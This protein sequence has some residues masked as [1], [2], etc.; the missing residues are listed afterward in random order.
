MAF[1]INNFVIDE[2]KRV[3]SRNPDTGAMN[4]L[5]AQIEDAQITCDSEEVTKNDAKGTPIAKWSQAKTANFSASNSLL[6]F[7]LMSWQFNGEGKTVATSGAAINAPA[8]EEHKIVSGDSLTEYVLANSVVAEADGSYKITVALLT[9]DGACKKNF[10]VITAG[11]VSTGKAK[12]DAT[13]HKLTFAS[14]DLAVGDKLFV[15]YEYSTENAVAIYNSADKYATAQE[16][17]V[18]VLGHD[19]CSVGTIY[20]GF[21]VFP[22]STLSASTTVALT[23]DSSFPFEFSAS[24]NYCDD[25]H[26]LFR[27]VIPQPASE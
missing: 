5:V 9:R 8:I 26:E 21:V 25:E 18:E 15:A 16:M 10:T 19:I 17:W 7:S 23:R 27:I 6:D 22:N 13:N 4:F 1:D 2:T 20:H 14:G 24:Q 11:D 3:F 12:Y